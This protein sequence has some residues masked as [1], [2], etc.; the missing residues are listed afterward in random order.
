MFDCW[1]GSQMYVETLTKRKRR[2]D[3]QVRQA[4]KQERRAVN[5]IKNVHTSPTRRQPSPVARST[6]VQV[7]NRSQA[8]ICTPMQGFFPDRGVLGRQG[9]DTD[10]SNGEV[11]AERRVLGPACGLV[12]GTKVLSRLA[13]AG[14]RCCVSGGC[15]RRLSLLGEFGVRLRMPSTSCV[16]LLFRQPSRADAR[17]W[18][19]LQ[20]L[21][22]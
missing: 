16:V 9:R 10:A 20:C 5:G 14:R 17:D 12:F 11:R 1:V 4:G 6:G 2:N 21:H 22:W 3:R 13:R 19:L 8:V 18:C 15:S 7:A